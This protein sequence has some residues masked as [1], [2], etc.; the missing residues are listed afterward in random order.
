MGELWC[1]LEWSLCL[2]ILVCDLMGCTSLETGPVDH[3]SWQ[4]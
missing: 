4:W 2:R 1:F 3:F